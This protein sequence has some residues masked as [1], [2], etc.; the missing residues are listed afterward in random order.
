MATR[1]EDVDHI[2][3]QL[4]PLPVAVR[5]MFGGHA[6]YLDGRVLGFVTDGVLCLKI[7]SFHDP[8][9]TEDLKGE[10][11]TG[12]RQYR[13]ITG[14]MWEDREWLQHV[15]GETAARVPTRAERKRV[16]RGRSQ[17]RR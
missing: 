9:L 6:L 3:D 13:R 1:E 7:T 16:V 12:S 15:V 5:R 17:R 8:R 11:Y 10:A 14:D 2:R 4:A